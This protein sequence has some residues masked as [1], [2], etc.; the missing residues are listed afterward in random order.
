VPV[1]ITPV[2]GSS[3]NFYATFNDPSTTTDVTIATATGISQISGS[4]TFP[5]YTGS[6]TPVLYLK[7][8][9]SNSVVF[10]QTPQIQVQGVTGSYSG[11]IFY[12]YDNNSG[13]AYVWTPT[14]PATGSAQFLS[15]GVTFNPA[16][17]TN[18]VDIT[19]TPFY[20]AI[21]CQ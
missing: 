7:I 4:P 5:I 19:T 2:T 17:L 15:G 6:G 20:A 8:T 9:A 18:G 16:A 11:C 13:S 1:E 3:I 14:I 12:G 21:V 10:P